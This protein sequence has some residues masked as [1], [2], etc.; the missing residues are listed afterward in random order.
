MWPLLLTAFLH[1]S[2]SFSLGLSFEMNHWVPQPEY[3]LA[4]YGGNSETESS[5]RLQQPPQPPA[6]AAATY[7]YCNNTSHSTQHPPLAPNLD[8]P[9]SDA[10]PYN[11][12]L[13]HSQ[14][15]T[16]SGSRY[17]PPASVT[18]APYMAPYQEPARGDQYRHFSQP[19]ERTS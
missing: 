16:A 10:A 4:G 2:E 6:A 7:D 8:F 19:L 11:F 14:E 9:V 1:G 5:S 12:Q 18:P 15:F 3:P 17:P 13:S